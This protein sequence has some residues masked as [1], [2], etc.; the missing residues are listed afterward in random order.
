VEAFISNS[1]ELRP[2]A[3]L[4]S[5]AHMAAAAAA[6]ATRAELI[7]K[8]AHPLAEVRTRAFR[9][10]ITKFA[11]RLPGWTVAALAAERELLAHVVG[12]FNDADG[13]AR[14]MQRDM[15][16]LVGAFAAVRALRPAPPPPPPPPPLA[17]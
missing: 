3:V 7:A 13:S 8:L 11:G 4:L 14:D 17:P 2:A 5:P 12:W 6:A 9:S 16:G 15:L 10:L 1:R